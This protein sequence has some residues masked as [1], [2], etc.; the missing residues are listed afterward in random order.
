MT[1][2]RTLYYGYAAYNAVDK[3]LSTV[4]KTYTDD[5]AGWINVKFDKTYFIHKVVFYFIFYTNWFH[6]K[7]GCVSSKPNFRYCVYQ[8]IGRDLEVSVY[9]GEVKQKS[10]G[11]LEQTTGLEQSDQILRS[12]D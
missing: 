7:D 4:A 2:G 12:T 6:P 3:D 10:C 1:Q 8:N 5:G 11:I 9:Q